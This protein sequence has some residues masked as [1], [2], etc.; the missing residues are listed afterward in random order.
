VTVAPSAAEADDRRSRKPSSIRRHSVDRFDRVLQQIGQRLRDQSPV[1]LRRKFESSE[2]GLIGARAIWG[3]LIELKVKPLPS[4]RTIQRILQRHSMTH[5]VGAATQTAY[6]PWL[7]IWETNAV[8]AT[9]IIARHIRGG[10]EIENFH[11]LDLFTHAAYLSQHTDK[12]STTIC[13]H[14]LDAWEKLGIP[15]IH[16]CDN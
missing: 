16:Q 1:E 15:C 3:K 2:G 8:H 13:E 14:L 12:T 6:Y 9:D 7:P 11:T 5:S 4:D 10:T